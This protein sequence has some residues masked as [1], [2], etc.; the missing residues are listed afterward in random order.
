MKSTISEILSINYSKELIFFMDGKFGWKW[1][2]I[3]PLHMMKFSRKSTLCL[4][5]VDC[6]KGF[7]SYEHEPIDTCPALLDGRKN[8]RMR[9]R[10]S[11]PQPQRTLEQRLNRAC[12]ASS[13]L[14]V[15][16][17]S[18]KAKDGL[19]KETRHDVG[20]EARSRAAQ[21]EELFIDQD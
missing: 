6:F 9:R 19:L 11:Y 14:K 16:K 21:H 13:I 5:R 12:L 10:A 18:S 7:G 15:E 17:N 3:W 1:Q 2:Y 4:S 8:L 20:K